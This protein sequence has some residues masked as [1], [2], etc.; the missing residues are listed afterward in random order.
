ML[1]LGVTELGNINHISLLLARSSIRILSKTVLCVLELLLSP[2]FFRVSTTISLTLAIPVLDLGNHRLLCL[3]IGVG[4]DNRINRPEV[5][6]L[7]H[8]WCRL[9]LFRLGGVTGAR[10]EITGVLT[11]VGLVRCLACL[12][13]VGLESRINEDLCL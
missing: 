4:V 9:A 13:Q 2:R 11:H 12:L 7:A 6:F 10:V 8:K 3:I 1:K 5:I